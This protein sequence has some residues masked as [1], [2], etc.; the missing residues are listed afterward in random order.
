VILFQFSLSATHGYKKGTLSVKRKKNAAPPVLKEK[1]KK[2][3]GFLL[4][5]VS[6]GAPRDSCSVLSIDVAERD[7][8]E[9]SCLS[10]SFYFFVIV[11]FGYSLVNI[12][13]DRHAPIGLLLFFFVDNNRILNCILRNQ[14]VSFFFS[15]L[16]LSTIF[17][18]F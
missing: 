7:A 9:S 17:Y 8:T 1:K 3:A 16:F 18:R 11:H 4:F 2:W 13:C 12:F 14:L 5:F 10:L 15:F 6:C